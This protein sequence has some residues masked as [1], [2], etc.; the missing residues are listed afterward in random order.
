MSSGTELY[1]YKHFFSIALYTLVDVNY[2]FLYVDLGCQ[3]RISGGVFKNTK[4][5]NKAKEK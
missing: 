3:G 1:N 4:L 2:N 5:Y